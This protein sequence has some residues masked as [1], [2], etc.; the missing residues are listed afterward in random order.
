M[1]DIIPTSRGT[2]SGKYILRSCAICVLEEKELPGYR[3]IV[4]VLSGE[5][6]CWDCCR[7]CSE[8]AEE[9]EE[10]GGLHGLETS[11]VWTD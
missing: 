10:S 9:G 5:V 7:A 2:I 3:V 11:V 4:A 1:P 6:D 8:E